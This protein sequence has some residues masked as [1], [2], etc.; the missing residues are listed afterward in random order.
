M[1]LVE[2]RAVLATDEF[3]GMHLCADCT[4]WERKNADPYEAA[5][6]REAQ[7]E[8][9]E[10]GHVSEARRLVEKLDTIV[11]DSIPEDIWIWIRA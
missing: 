8:A 3:N 4:E 1:C 9:V 2:G 6:Q 5:E 10:A 7:R 11:R